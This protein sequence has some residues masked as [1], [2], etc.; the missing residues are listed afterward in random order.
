M[1][2]QGYTSLILEVLLLTKSD[3]KMCSKKQGEF[4]R[5]KHEALIFVESNGLKHCV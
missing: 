4:F 3:L 1:I 5:N 2:N